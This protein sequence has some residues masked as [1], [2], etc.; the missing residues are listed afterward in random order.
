MIFA[1]EVFFAYL[2]ICSLQ[3]KTCLKT[4]YCYTVLDW[5][6]L[7]T[8]LLTFLLWLEVNMLKVSKGQHSSQ[9]I[10][11]NIAHISP[12]TA[13]PQWPIALTIPLTGDRTAVYRCPL[14]PSSIFAHRRLFSYH[15]DI[16][17]H[18]RRAVTAPLFVG[19]R[20]C[21]YYDMSKNP[22]CFGEQCQ[23]GWL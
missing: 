5:K 4:W 1:A 10:K 17:T 14:E 8:L 6:K 20:Q 18:P 15:R 16:L 21:K 19:E 9:P 7:Y 22:A 12:H 23:R 3:L 13:W 2:L 11:W